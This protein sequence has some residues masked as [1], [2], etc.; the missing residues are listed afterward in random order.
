MEIAYLFMPYMLAHML[1]FLF[2]GKRQI[3]FFKRNVPGSQFLRVMMA[4]VYWIAILSSGTRGAYVAFICVAV[5]AGTVK[6]FG[7]KDWIKASLPIAMLIFMFVL[8]FVWRP[9]GMYR[10][11]R[12]DVVIDSV[13]KSDFKTDD[14]EG[15]Q[16]GE[17]VEQYANAFETGTSEEENRQNDEVVAERSNSI[18]LG[19]IDLY[20]LALY[21]FKNKP[22]LGRGPLGFYNKYGAYT[23]NCILE[24]LADTGIVGALLYLGVIIYILFR[25]IFIRK[26]PM[27]EIVVISFLISYMVQLN[28]SGCVWRSTSAVFFAVG[29]GAMV[30]SDKGRIEREGS[31]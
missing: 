31:V 6:I 3:V 23:H 12:W 7:G 5:V 9:H 24:I 17:E 15:L 8:A 27:H 10:M 13:G 19:R 26:K 20:R 21:E 16:N 25:W 18:E 14:V 22:L 2:E 28:I 1:A 4:F 30:I 29:Y 11:S